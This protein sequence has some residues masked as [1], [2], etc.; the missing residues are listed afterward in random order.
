MALVSENLTRTYVSSALG[1][2]SRTVSASVTGTRTVGSPDVV[3]VKVTI[4]AI[5]NLTEAELA[6]YQTFV[7]T[8]DEAAALVE[9]LIILDTAS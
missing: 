6:S 5:Q 9:D 2:G 4:Q 1:D 7:G 8:L 3:E